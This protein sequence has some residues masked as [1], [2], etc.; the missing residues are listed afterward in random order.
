MPVTLVTPETDSTVL[1]LTSVPTTHVTQTPLAQT[2]RA[3]TSAHVT[4]ATPETAPH[5]PMSTSVPIAHAL[6]MA[7]VLIPKAQII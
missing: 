3:V 5:V 2:H 4:R 6:K 1:T 7:A